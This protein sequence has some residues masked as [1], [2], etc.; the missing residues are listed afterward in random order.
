MT[1]DR[2]GNYWDWPEFVAF[3]V[4]GAMLVIAG[5]TYIWSERGSSDDNDLGEAVHIVIGWFII[6]YLICISAVIITYSLDVIARVNGRRAAM[7]D[8]RK[9]V[10]SLRREVGSMRSE[11]TKRRA[12]RTSRPVKRKATK[13]GEQ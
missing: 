2:E 4:I 12:V 5:W 11:M 7:V 9:E 8:L 10:T 6:V 1:T 3:V 13:R